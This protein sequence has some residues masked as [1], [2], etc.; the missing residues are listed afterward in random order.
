MVVWDKSVYLKEAEK[1]QVMKK[2]TKKLKLQK[3]DQVELVERSNKIFSNLRRKNVITENENSYFRLNL[4]K[5]TN[6]GKR[7][8]HPKIHEGFCNVPWRTVI[9]NCDI[10]T[11]KSFRILGSPFTAYNEIRRVSHKRNRRRSQKKSP[12]ELL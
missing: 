9:S 3:K 11:E 1:Q 12:K 8:L 6:L 5:A 4:K 2:L 7:Y 10:P